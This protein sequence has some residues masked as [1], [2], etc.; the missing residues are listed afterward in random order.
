[1]KIHS[2]YTCV[3]NDG[4]QQCPGERRSARRQES[5]NIAGLSVFVRCQVG[6]ISK[7]RFATAGHGSHMGTAPSHIY[8]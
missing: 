2:L 4:E 1:M 7:Q 6:R 5:D 8:L 3:E